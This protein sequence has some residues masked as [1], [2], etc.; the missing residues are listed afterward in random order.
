LNLGKKNI[1]NSKIVNKPVRLEKMLHAARSISEGLDFCRVDF[2][3]VKDEIY[4]G[5][6]CFYPEGGYIVFEPH[7]FNKELYESAVVSSRPFSEKYYP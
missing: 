5:E 4:F 6:V 1:N 7:D 3:V 2:Y